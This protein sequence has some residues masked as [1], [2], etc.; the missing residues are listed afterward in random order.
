MISY[1]T[2]G[3]CIKYH[4]DWLRSGGQKKNAH[5]FKNCV[6]PP[7]FNS[8]EDRLFL[9]IIPPPELHLLIGIVNTVYSHMLINHESDALNWAK[10]CNVQRIITHGNHGFEGNSCKKLLN[11]VDL[12]RRDSLHCLEYVDVLQKFNKV[13]DACFGVSLNEN[14]KQYVEDFKESYLKLGTPITPKVHAVFFHVTDFC[15]KNERGLGFYGEQAMES[16]HHDFN[17]T[18]MK[19]KVSQQNPKYGEQLF[20]AVCEYN[21]NHM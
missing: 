10:V 6:N 3:H 2:I 1:R 13:V 7:V 8:D 4:V 16:V 17:V 5:K 19:Y 9:D 14:Y 21:S 20:W 15:D 12:L 18:W 11:K